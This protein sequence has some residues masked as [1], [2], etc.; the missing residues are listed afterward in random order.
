M[1]RSGENEDQQFAVLGDKIDGLADMLDR[2]E[3]RL[4]SLH[5]E[6]QRTASA[7]QRMILRQEGLAKSLARLEALLHER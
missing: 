7:G 6:C 3:A 2:L 1:R 4:D 5:E